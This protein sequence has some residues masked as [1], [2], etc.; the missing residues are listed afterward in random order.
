[1]PTTKETI[2]EL[3]TQI[4][5]LS[6]SIEQLNGELFEAKEQ[7]RLEKESTKLMWKEKD[8]LTQLLQEHGIE[9]PE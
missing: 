6:T 5:T 7:L 2:T 8:K 1:M 3:E 9:I 4:Q